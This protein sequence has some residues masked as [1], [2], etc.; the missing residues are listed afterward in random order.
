MRD[1][2]E[3]YGDKVLL[4]IAFILAALMIRH[5]VLENRDYEFE[6]RDPVGYAACQLWE[7]SRWAASPFRQDLRYR[8]AE[9]ALYADT[10]AIRH[11]PDEAESDRF[12]QVMYR[13]ASVEEVRDTCA[14]QGY[15]FENYRMADEPPHRDYSD[16]LPDNVDPEIA[17]GMPAPEDSAK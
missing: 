17:T 3:E 1:F 13:R 10:P 11:L 4:L 8:S 6:K 5:A 16:I 14:A 15:R 9:I 12:G 7:D 2:V